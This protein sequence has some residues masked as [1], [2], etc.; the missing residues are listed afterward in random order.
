LVFQDHTAY[1]MRSPFES[2][3]S[4]HGEPL[5]VVG[6]A[7][8]TPSGNIVSLE[9]CIMN[10]EDYTRNERHIELRLRENYC[11]NIL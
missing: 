7:A 11:V 5:C 4:G 10:E 2:D 1:A 9:I 6:E 8:Q 3:A